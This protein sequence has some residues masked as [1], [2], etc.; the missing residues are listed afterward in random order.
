MRLSHY[1]YT[2]LASLRHKP[3]LHILKQHKQRR[4]NKKQGT[5]PTSIPPTVPTPM[6]I[7][8]LA[9]TPVANIMGNIPKII[10]S[11]VISIGLRRTPAAEIAA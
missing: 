4:N 2:L 10:V 11:D 9:P 3:F 6:D 1:V 5:V 8:P 7:L